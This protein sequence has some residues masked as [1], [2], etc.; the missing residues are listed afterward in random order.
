MYNCF[1]K[2]FLENKVLT[3]IW[4][5]SWSFNWLAIIQLNDEIFEAFEN[6]LYTPAV[7]IDLSKSFSNSGLHDIA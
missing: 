2:Y 3:L 4:F 7:L 5:S 1:H 6:N